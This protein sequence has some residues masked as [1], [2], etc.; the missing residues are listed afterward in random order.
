M[1]LNSRLA[2]GRAEPFCR[3]AANFYSLKIQKIPA[4]MVALGVC[5]GCY[6][7]GNSVGI[8]PNLGLGTDQFILRGS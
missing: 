6:R 2:Q 1:L 4:G 7:V 5:L 3:L 8:L